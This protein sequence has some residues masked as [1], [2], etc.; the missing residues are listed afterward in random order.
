MSEPQP[1]QRRDAVSDP[2]AIARRLREL[3]RTLASLADLVVVVDGDR[4]VIECHGA[5]DQIWGLARSE[6]IGRPMPT[7]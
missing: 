2:G 5:C 3:E 1:S 6:V 4:R 7:Y